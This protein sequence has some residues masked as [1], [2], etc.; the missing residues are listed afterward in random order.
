IAEVDEKS[1][2]QLGRWPWPRS[3]FAKITESLSSLEASVIAFD[4]IFSS[5]EKNPLED[6]LIALD[7]MIPE[8]NTEISSAKIYLNQLINQQNPDDFFSKTLSE[9]SPTV[10]GYFFHFSSDGLRHLTEEKRHQYFEDIKKSQFRAFLKSQAD[11][12]L[13]NLPFPIAYAIESNL[14]S[15]SDAASG[16]GYLTFNVDIDGMIRRLPLMVRYHDNATKKDYYFPPLSLR[17]LETYLDGTLLFR[18]GE[19]GMEEVIMDA[20]ESAI[21]PTN[22][23]GELEINHLGP[24]GTFSSFSISDLLQTDKLSELKEKIKGNIVLIGATATALED[25]RST[26]FDPVLPGVEIHATVLDNYF[27]KSFLSPASPLYDLLLIIITGILCTL[28]YSR[29]K[30]VAGLFFW[31]LSSALLFLLSHWFFIGKG[32]WLTDIY[33]FFTNTSIAALLMINQFLR[34][35]EQ[36]K[37]IKEVFGQYLSPRVVKDLL[38]DTSRLKLGGEQKVLSAFFTDLANFT[39]FSEKLSAEDLVSLLNHYFT[40]MTDILIKNDGTLDRYDGDAI[41]AFFG[42]PLY[43]ED[44]AKRACW[45]CIEMQ[46]RLSELRKEYKQ[47]GK[48][49]LVMR[50]GINTGEMV[51]GNM[52]SSTRMN[53][54]MNGD[55]VNLAARL[56]GANKQYG[57]CALISES[58]YQEAKDYIEVRELD[59]LRVVGRATPIKIYEL[60]GKKGSNKFPK[61]LPDYLEGL[62]NYK[63]Q[64]WDTAI[65][66][67]EN[68]LKTDPEDGPSKTY[69]ERCKLF[70]ESPPGKDWDGVFNLTKK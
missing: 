19:A 66:S 46:E 61:A 47:Q 67:F 62:K 50:V 57:T 29:I 69:I 24:R 56:E 55:S 63:A 34:E 48:P 37:F 28:I 13:Y 60:L 12:D 18:V 35:E 40:E 44:H 53:Y 51:V 3:T 14:A 20:D 6:N 38:T 11:M 43:F 16:S 32:F 1:I 68:A 45:T 21:I 36:T 64:K 17:I 31:V 8:N 23:R 15:F 42:A 10:L 25:L 4:I 7:K 39:T 30:P 5:P 70:M 22:Y 54:G 26:P 58:T 33:P 9:G 65:E 49:E 41:K 2:D 59:T 27:N 52:G